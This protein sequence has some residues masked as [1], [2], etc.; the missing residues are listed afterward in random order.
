MGR[1]A[2]L[3]PL[4]RV[5]RLG[6]AGPARSN[7]PAQKGANF[8]MRETSVRVVARGT[9]RRLAVRTARVD[10][11]DMSPELLQKL[12]GRLRQR[13]GVA[14]VPDPR[15][16]ARLIVATKRS[17]E[18]LRLADDNWELEMTD[19]GAPEEL[20]TLTDDLGRSVL[21]QLVERAFLATIARSSHLRMYGSPRI[22]YEPQPFCLDASIAAHRRYEI[23]ALLAD[24]VGIVIAVDIG[25]AFFTADSLA[26][27]YDPSQSAGERRAREQHLNGLLGRQQ[28]QKGTLQYDTGDTLSVCYFVQAPAGVTCG[29]TG[30]RRL[31]NTTYASLAEYYRAKHPEFG[32]TDDLVAVQVSFP[33]LDRPQWVVAERVRARVMNEHLPRNLTQV[34]KL[35]PE[36]RRTL[37]THFW[38]Q[39]GARPLGRIGQELATEFWRPPSNA[40]TRH[41]PVALTY[42]RGARIPAATAPT[43]EAYRTHYRQRLDAPNRQWVEDMT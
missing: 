21:P 41:A 16:P 19:A 24:E 9:A 2:V 30:K 6:S 43:R 3:R 14:A 29:T 27:F 8:G 18:Q 17:I 36:E 4:P 1:L 32:D 35:D 12:C 5:S 26:Y 7:A 11:T 20:L 25:T 42:G 40:I 38:D 15:A 28:R 37:I 10:G 22:W 23:G 33:N 39:L 13:H 34:D 31:N